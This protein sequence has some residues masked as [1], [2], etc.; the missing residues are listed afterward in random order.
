MASAE[1]SVSIVIPA[2]NEAENLDFLLDEIG[3]ALK[4]QAYEIIVVDDGS[5]DD[6]G[7]VLARKAEAGLPLRHIRHERAFGKSMA[8]RSGLAV[9]R[10]EI[11]VT[12]DGDG[13]NDPVY[14]PPLVKALRDGGAETGLAAGERQN[15]T[16]GSSKKYASRFANRLRK[17]LLNDDTVDSGCGF[18]AVRREIFMTLPYFDGWHR[19]LPALVKREGFQIARIAIVDRPR[20][21][22]QSYYGILDR[23]TRG[24]VDL[25]GVWW[26]TRRSR[27]RPQ[28]VERNLWNSRSSRPSPTGST[29]SSSPA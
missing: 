19:F 1:P 16:D 4:D 2:R 3:A 18:K 13:Q 9:A 12:V 27:G 22:G 29:T 11:V 8:L 7:A 25:L 26:L 10:G 24:F 6:T 5:D 21:Y 20:K 23:G 17:K 15:R 28:A 14:I